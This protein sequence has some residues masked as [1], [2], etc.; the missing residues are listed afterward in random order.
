MKKLHDSI[1]KPMAIIYC[2]VSTKGQEE[3]GTSLDSQEAACRTFAEQQGYSVG[4]VTREV[5]TGAELWDRP[6]LA[7]DR[8][9]IKAGLFQ[10]LI[11]FAIDRLT[12]DPI[13]L[14]IISDE[15]E[16]KGAALEFVTEPLDSSPEA[17]LIRY[18]KGY[19]AA[20]EREKI[21]ERNLRGKRQRAI[22]GKVHGHGP[23]LY[24][25]RRDKAAGVRLVYEPEAAII[26]R[27]FHGYVLDGQS[28]KEIIRRLNDQGI[29]PPSVGKLTFPDAARRPRWAKG[30]IHRILKNPTYAGRGIAW[31][32]QSQGPKKSPLVRPQEEWITL[33]DGTTPALVTPEI[34]QA[35]Q[36]RLHSNKGEHSR[37]MN[38]ARQYLLRGL[39]TCGVCGCAMYSAPHR[40]KRAYRCSSRDKPQGACGGRSVPAPEAEAWVW[41]EVTAMLR[42][43]QMIAD[44]LKRR[45]EAGPDPMLESDLEAA[46]KALAKAEKQQGQW[47]A[48]LRDTDD[49]DGALWNL[50]KAE[51]ARLDQEKRDLHATMED[52]QGRM[53]QQQHAVDKLDALHVYCARVGQ[54]L[55][56]FGFDEQRLALEALGI[57][58]TANGREWQLD[59]SI[60]LESGVL[61]PAILCT[62]QNAYTFR[63]LSTKQGA[64][65]L[66][67]G[68]L[69]ET[70]KVKA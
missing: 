60:P 53:S 44:E 45:Q 67:V 5:Y 31:R 11:V 1:T 50:V 10:A 69:V 57:R 19:A 38:K 22:S 42:N 39:V 49:D 17:S 29:S 58:V 25:Y 56:S 32:F 64:V 34:W 61:S 65:A 40:D 16:R 21:R 26:Q 55:E 30:Q 51:A 13:H 33:P 23:E 59:G 68:D 6:K 37:N 36:D 35:A 8:D 63:F 66:E 3:D 18:V 54:N 46:R 62:V 70:L 41:G 52:I 4:R 48:R 12:R 15:C 14:M 20:M 43:P 28:L 9:D 47:V 7:Q 2:R 27:I 24:G